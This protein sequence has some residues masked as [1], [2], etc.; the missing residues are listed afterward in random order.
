MKTTDSQLEVFPH[1]SVAVYR[2]ES[3]PELSEHASGI[4]VVSE[5]TTNCEQLS[6]TCGVKTG[7]GSEQRMVSGSGQSEKIGA[8]SSMS[9]STTHA[10]SIEHPSEM[11][12]R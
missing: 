11:V 7:R 8:M 1:E 12:Y 3:T 2:I 6:E 9:F 4:Q 5:V 10:V